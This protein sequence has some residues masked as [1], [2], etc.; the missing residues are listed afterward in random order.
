[1]PTTYAV[2][3]IDKDGEVIGRSRVV[4]VK[5]PPRAD[6][7]R[8]ACGLVHGDVRGVACKWSEAQHPN[9]ARYVLYRSVDGG[10]REAIHR[11]GLDGRR[12]FLDQDLERGQTIRYSVVVLDKDGKVVGRSRVVT[13]KLPPR[14]ARPAAP[15]A[16]A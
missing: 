1:M 16:G 15:A 2:I 11:A 6:V 3:A 9:A 13:V 4:T 14:D 10:A 12:S 8:L 5:L 7:L